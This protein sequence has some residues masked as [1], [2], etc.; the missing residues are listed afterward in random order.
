MWLVLLRSP[1][2]TQLLGSSGPSAGGKSKGGP[3]LP[4]ILTNPLQVVWASSDGG[5]THSHPQKEGKSPS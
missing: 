4:L 1:V 3:L 5:P 2:E